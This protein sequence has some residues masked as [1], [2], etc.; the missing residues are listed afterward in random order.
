[1]KLSYG[2]FSDVTPVMMVSAT[3]TYGVGLL[4][5]IV[6][7]FCNLF[8]IECVLYNRKVEAANRSATQYL[9]QKAEQGGADGIMGIQ[10][11]LHGLTVLMYGVAYKGKS[12]M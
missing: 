6:L 8:G 12:N 7:G 1:M 9:I 10:Y 5:Y 3:A 2:I 4:T 11:Q